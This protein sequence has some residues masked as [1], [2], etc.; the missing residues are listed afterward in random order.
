MLALLVIHAVCASIFL[1]LLSMVKGA[2]FV[3]KFIGIYKNGWQY[4]KN[5]I[6]ILNLLDRSGLDVKGSNMRSVSE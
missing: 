3:L 2:A 4:R 5:I 1:H 6:T